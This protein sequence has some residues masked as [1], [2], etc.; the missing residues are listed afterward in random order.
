[1]S[2]Y[3]DS[4]IIPEY[5]GVHASAGPE[6]TVDGSGNIQLMLPNVLNGTTV[7]QA[8]YITNNKSSDTV[9]YL[10]TEYNSSSSS[11]TPI[12]LAGFVNGSS[13][14]QK[15]ITNIGASTARSWL[16]ISQGTTAPTTLAQGN[17]FFLYNE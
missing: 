14:S 16:G 17:I 13:S 9:T 7:S 15:K 5:D 12:S 2:L 3:H 8:N 10:A 6:H 11:N 4:C 1:M